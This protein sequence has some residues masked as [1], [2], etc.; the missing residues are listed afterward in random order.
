MQT[1]LN[2]MVI[3]SL[4]VQNVFAVLRPAAAAAI[5]AKPQ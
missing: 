2:I 5:D 4:A 3:L 1:A